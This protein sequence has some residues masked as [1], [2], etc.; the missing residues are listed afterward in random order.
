M[1]WFTPAARAS[2]MSTIEVGGFISLY[3]HGEPR[4]VQHEHVFASSFFVHD[5]LEMMRFMRFI[6]PVLSHAPPKRRSLSRSFSGGLVSLSFEPRT[7]LQ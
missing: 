4:P 1:M 6:E 3:K 2:E 7:W 5:D